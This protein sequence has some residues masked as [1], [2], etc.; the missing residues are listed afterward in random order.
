MRYQ[1][2]VGISEPLSREL[3]YSN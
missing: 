2:E 1:A 3:V